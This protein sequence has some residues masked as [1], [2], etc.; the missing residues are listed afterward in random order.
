MEK[1]ALDKHLDISS[2][3]RGRVRLPSAVQGTRVLAYPKSSPRLFIKAPQPLPEA[4]DIFMALQ[5]KQTLLW[6][7]EQ[8]MVNMSL[9]FQNHKHV[10]PSPSQSMPLPPSTGWRVK[11]LWKP[12]EQEMLSTCRFTVIVLAIQEQSNGPW[13]ASIHHFS[14]T[15]IH[16]S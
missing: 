14:E 15:W 5:F 4:A 7:Q 13:N 10:L 1:V 2:D 6:G 12:K 8:A 9:S 11:C 16:I 3:G